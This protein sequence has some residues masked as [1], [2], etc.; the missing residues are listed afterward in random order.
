[1][2][3]AP[4]L[5]AVG[6]VVLGV[7]W[8]FAYASKRIDRGGAIY[9]VFA[10]L[11]QRRFDGLDTEL[12]GIMKERG[13]RADDPF[14]EVVAT[15]E[16]MEAGEGTDFEEMTAK[17]ADRLAPLVGIDAARIASQFLEGTRVG[18]TPVTRGVALP[19]LRLPDISRPYLVVV[20]S[21]RGISID[22]GESMPS[23][24]SHQDV[25]AIFFLVSPVGDPALH[26]R[27]LAQL[28]GCVEQE[29]FQDA[30]TSARSHQ[31]LREVLLRDDRYL[32]LVLEPGS[33]AE[34]I[35][36]LKI[37]EVDFPSGSLVALVRR[38]SRTLVPT[39]SLQLEAD[40]RLTVI[41]DEEAIATLKTAYLP[42]PPVLPSA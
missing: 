5:F 14:D 6:M 39:G 28:A 30:W 22:V 24:T 33:P 21:R 38:G 17:A 27:I 16:I 15:S 25:R 32:S 29:G 3:T 4:T 26:L 34:A 8:F 41:G 37:R 31:A 7:V 42:E 35:A 19:H 20:R 40:D 13:L 2:G 1:M 36:G 11:G 23:T 12:R 10:R 18:A 9:H